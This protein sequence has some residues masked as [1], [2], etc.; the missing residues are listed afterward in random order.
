MPKSKRSKA[1]RAAAP[2]L[3]EGARV[4]LR[5]LKRSDRA[6]SVAWRNDPAIRDNVMG[7][8]FPVTAEMEKH[9]VE[10]VLNDQSRSRVVLAIEDRSDR[11]LAG[12]VYLFD[13]DWISRTAEFGILIG[14]RKRQGRGLA[15]EALALMAHHAFRV[16]N[17]HRLYLRVPAYNRR[18]AALYRRFGFKEEGRLRQQ[19]FL[20]RRHHDVLV[21]GLLRREYERRTKPLTP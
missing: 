21:M 15:R 3:Y 19:V 16:L 12:F 10:R 8:R 20:G 2:I 5:P 17:L 1:R 18:A 11:K 4:I 7:Y 14:E 13:I 9:W 6:A